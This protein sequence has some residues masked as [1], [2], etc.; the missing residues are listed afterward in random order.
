M[1][2]GKLV[3]S[4]SSPARSSLYSSPTS[5]LT[6]PFLHPSS[7]VSKSHTAQNPDLLSA[8]ESMYLKRARSLR[9]LSRHAVASSSTASMP[10]M[11]K[12]AVKISSMKTLAKLAMGAAQP[13]IRAA[14]AGDGHVASVTKAGDVLFR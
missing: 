7:C 11:P 12:T 1:T 8:L 5:H 4:S 2:S 14:A 13:L 9:S 3:V 10:A 6:V